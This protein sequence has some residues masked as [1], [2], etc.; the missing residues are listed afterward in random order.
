MEDKREVTRLTAKC[1]PMGQIQS[2]RNIR[3]DQRSLYQQRGRKTC[4]R[5]H[6]HWGERIEN[7]HAE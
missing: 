6:M 5:T 1:E 2:R 7:P 4:D 3:R